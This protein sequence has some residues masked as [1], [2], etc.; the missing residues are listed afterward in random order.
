MAA[1][2]KWSK[3]PEVGRKW[4]IIQCRTCYHACDYP[5][6]SPNFVDLACNACGTRL[7]PIGFQVEGGANGVDIISFEE[8]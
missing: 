8:D 2:I 4:V 1:E 6:D 7:F 3:K 5:Y